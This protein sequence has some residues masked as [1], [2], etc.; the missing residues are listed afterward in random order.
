MGALRMLIT[1]ATGFLGQAVV[2]EA[3]TRGH[4]VHALQRS[5]ASSGDEVA[6]A[7]VFRGDLAEP[8]DWLDQALV[9]VDVIIHVAA[10][11]SGDPSAHDRDTLAA[12]AS[13]CAA[14]RRAGVS[15]MVLISSIAVYSSAAH[16]EGALVTEETPLMRPDAPG[17]DAYARAKR[18]QEEIVRD[19]GFPELWVLRPGAIYGPSRTWNANVGPSVGPLLLRVGAGGEVP[20]LQVQSAARA[21]LDAAET[22][23]DLIGEVLNLVDMPLPD[24]AE[25]V[26]AHQASGWPRHVLP[27]PW[28]I[29]HL[30]ARGIGNLIG[31]GWLLPDTARARM[32]PVRYTSAAAQDRLNWVPESDW[33]AGLSA[34]MGGQS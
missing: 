24:R 7:T 3:D 18:A 32:M 10:S 21:I 20:L 15:R 23:P 13:L 1:G 8:G 16:L 27:V 31:S 28:F 5:D 19:A 34:A 17:R 25:F 11:M 2:S 22:R 12:T 9:D 26:Q 29:W 33:R 14:A 6:N 4:A 30:L